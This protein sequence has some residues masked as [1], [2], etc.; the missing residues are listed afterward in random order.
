MNGEEFINAAR[1]LAEE[2]ETPTKVSNRMLWALAVDAYHERKA[3][4]IRVHRLEDA[5]MRKAALWGGLAGLLT[6]LA[7]IAVILNFFL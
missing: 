6:T 3:I 2:K 7:S 4:N 5:S 1:Y